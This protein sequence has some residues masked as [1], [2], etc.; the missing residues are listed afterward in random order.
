MIAVVD[1]QPK[2]SVIIRAAPPPRLRSG[3]GEAHAHPGLG[4][5]HRGGQPGEPGA[6]NRRARER[7]RVTTSRATVHSKAGLL[8]R[9]RWRGGA[10]PTVSIRVSNLA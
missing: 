1:R 7:Q 4:Q 6:G 8:T 5:P 2:L 9:T 3:I 10:Q